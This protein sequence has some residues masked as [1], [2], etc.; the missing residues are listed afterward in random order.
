MKLIWIT[1]AYGVKGLGKKKNS[2]D[3]LWHLNIMVH[4]CIIHCLSSIPGSILNS[5]DC[6][7]GVIHSYSPCAHVGF[8]QILWFP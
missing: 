5:G 8:H 3:L 7:C 4:C 2:S 6:L 1:C